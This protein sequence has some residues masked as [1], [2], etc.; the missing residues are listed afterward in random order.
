MLVAGNGVFQRKA[1]DALKIAAEKHDRPDLK[2]ARDGIV[3]VRVCVAII[4][5]DDRGKLGLVVDRHA[6]GDAREGLVGRRVDEDLGQ[7]IQ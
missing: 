2:W 6:P 4:A 3:A 5:L 1:W 7:C